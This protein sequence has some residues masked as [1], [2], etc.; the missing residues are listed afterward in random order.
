[1]METQFIKPAKTYKKSIQYACLL[2]MVIIGT[3]T[4]FVIPQ[5]EEKQAY[6]WLTLF[7]AALCFSFFYYYKSQEKAFTLTF[8]HLHYH[9]RKGGWFARWQDIQSIGQ[10]QLNHQ[11]WYQPLPWIGIKLKEYDT[12]LQTISPRLAAKFLLEDK[13]LLL[14]A[15]REQPEMPYNIDELLFDDTEYISKKGD[16]FT[17][18]QAML[19]NRMKYNR[20]YFDF[21]FFISEEHFEGEIGNFIGLLRRYL[22]QSSHYEESVLPTKQ[23]E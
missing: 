5:Q 19:A 9:C 14:M 12:F 18:L 11:G 16:K 23:K 7:I 17:G 21:D 6:L 1:M 10:A 3:I 20:E 15:Y 22:A 2:L 8:M 13:T 4:L